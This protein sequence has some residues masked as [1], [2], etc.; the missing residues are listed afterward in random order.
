L[1]FVFDFLA[2]L[3]SDF[4]VTLPV[5]STET[6]VRAAGT[7]GLLI[8]RSNRLLRSLRLRI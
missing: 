1:K 8:I 6:M 5:P 3:L 4:L 7:R 2:K